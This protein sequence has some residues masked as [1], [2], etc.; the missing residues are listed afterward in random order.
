MGSFPPL[1]MTKPLKIEGESA[2]T[3][4]S[5]QSKPLQHSASCTML[6]SL[7]EVRAGRTTCLNGAAPSTI[8]LVDLAVLGTRFV[9]KAR[10]PEPKPQKVA[11]DAIHDPTRTPHDNAIN[12][13]CSCRHHF[14][15]NGRKA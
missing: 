6:I 9:A 5:I 11:K 12:Q 7:L 10:I 2:I 8:F 13:G 3:L 14:V 15:Q 4:S 1:G